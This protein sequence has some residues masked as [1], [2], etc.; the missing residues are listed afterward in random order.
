MFKRCPAA[1]LASSHAHNACADAAL[2][3]VIPDP[4]RDAKPIGIPGCKNA[5][6]NV[7]G[8]GR[9]VRSNPADGTADPKNLRLGAV[10]AGPRAAHPRQLTPLSVHA[11]AA[12]GA[13]FV[14]GDGRGHSRLPDTSGWHANAAN[15]GPSAYRLHYSN[16]IANAAARTAVRIL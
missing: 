9:I 8:E 10:C 6:A 11:A 16:E 5:C 14:L 7:H 1:A 3:S 12:D 15:A 2:D 13:D 4:G